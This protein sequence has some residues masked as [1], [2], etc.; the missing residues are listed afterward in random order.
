M[1]SCRSL[2]RCSTRL[3]AARDVVVFLADDL[4]R[5]R[6]RGR[7]Q[8]IDRRVDPQLRDRALEHDRRVEVREGRRRRGIGQVVGRNVDRLERGDRSLLGRGDPLLQHAHLGAQRRLV[9]DGA[10]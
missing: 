3:H 2:K 6:A 8:R 1:M 10:G 9:A 5:E 4:G 7:R